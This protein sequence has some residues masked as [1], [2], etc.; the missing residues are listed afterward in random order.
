MQL[1]LLFSYLFPLRVYDA[2]RPHL[3][4]SFLHTLSGDSPVAIVNVPPGFHVDV[5]LVSTDVRRL[6]VLLH[7]VLVEMKTRS[8]IVEWYHFELV[9]VSDIISMSFSCVY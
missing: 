9:S 5:H 8:D 4:F 6:L 3:S 2:H 7:T 1:S